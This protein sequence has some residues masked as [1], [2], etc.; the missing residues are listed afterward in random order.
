MI[1]AVRAAVTVHLRARDHSGALLGGRSVFMPTRAR[2]SAIVL[3]AGG[4]SVACLVRTVSRAA[5]APPAGSAA[6]AGAPADVGPWAVVK[7]L[8]IGGEGRWDYLTVDPA[9]KL[10]YVPRSTHTQIIR[11]DSGELAGDLKDTAGVHGV[12]LVPDVGRGF[13]SNGRAN[14]VTVFD[15][16]TL[17]PIGNVATGQNP[18]GILYDP[19]SKRV[20][21]FNG[22]SNDA[23]VIVPDGDPTAK[24]TVAATIPL[25][26]KPE[27]AASDGAGH[28]Y[29]NLEDKSSIAA[30]DSK[31]M[32]VIATWKI[33][34][35]EEP[36]GLALDAARHR[37]FAGC[38]NQVMAVVD[39]ESGKTL[40][41]VPIGKNVDF[42]AF[43]PGTGEAFASCGDSTLTV[44][45][46]TAPGK[47]DV[48]QTVRTPAGARTMGLDPMTHTLY[49]PTAEFEK[50]AG[51]GG[52]GR[53]PQAKPDSFMI[54]VVAREASR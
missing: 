37:L 26:G 9:S 43:D 35:G 10:L 4:I 24:E 15:L 47:F 51:G 39:S 44:V 18:D 36:S 54:V 12:A 34:G 23:T 17:Q 16:K 28:V 13:T 38:G 52:G 21:A 41:T 32:K 5:D 50:P 42:C 46:E 19:A 29:V 1:R 25:G 27:S 49:L 40:G 45:K 8:R 20:F 2:F 33:E 30:I 7:T 6:V 14:N 3:L 53:R 48:V 31:A 22:R 11:A